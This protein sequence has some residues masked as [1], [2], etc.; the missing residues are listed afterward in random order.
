MTTKQK[1]IIHIGA[2]PL[3]IESI[4]WA[5][6]LGLYVIVTDQNHDAPGVKYAHEYYQLPGNDIQSLVKLATDCNNRF[7]IIAAYTSSDFGL[8]PV[9]AIHSK[10]GLQGCSYEAAL[11]SLDKYSSKQIWLQNDILTPQ[12]RKFKSFE[13][14]NDELDRFHYP[15][16][17]KPLD[18][19]GS[20]GV[21]SINSPVEVK[22]AITNALQ[23]S[24]E[25]LIEEYIDGK[26]YDT[27][28]IVWDGKFIP[29]GIGNRF[30]SEKPFHFPLY[31]YTPADL[32]YNEI[33]CAYDVTKKAVLALGINYS[34]VKADLLYYNNSFYVIEVAPRF[35]GD[36]FASKL[37]PYSHAASPI[38]KLFE[39][40]SGYTNG[41]SYQP[42]A[43]NIVAWRAIFPKV[44]AIDAEAL[45][46]M[47]KKEFNLIDHYFKNSRKTS[48]IIKHSDNSSLEGFF[49]VIFDS[50]D[51]LSHFN[52][53]FYEK[54]GD[55]LL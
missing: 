52:N 43:D 41:L 50:R 3:Q 53:S 30:F 47:L 38:R 40:Q 46:E 20:Q 31:G 42:C 51:D 4:N 11:K 39:I 37:I 28:G 23:F 9:A 26:S 6:K 44:P 48:G 29:C 7:N 35:H 8:L 33:Q 22:N 54:F 19:C 5:K 45:L 49:W 32:D 21:L 2:G 15:V 55:M 10:L 25:A 1:A 24:S 18:S 17:V 14:I 12:A 16:I 34:P 27:I 13:E 36:V